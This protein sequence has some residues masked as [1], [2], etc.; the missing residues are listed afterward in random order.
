MSDRVQTGDCG[1]YRF[2]A[3]FVSAETGL[4]PCA[5]APDVELELTKRLSASITDRRA[6]SFMIADSRLLAPDSE[7][8][9]LFPSQLIGRIAASSSL[10][11]S[12]G[13][14]AG[15][16]GSQS[17]GPNP[18]RIRAKAAWS[19]LRDVLHRALKALR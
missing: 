4:S 2:R 8:R 11:P 16:P 1:I 13:V 9:L 10:C 17:S 15:R 5:Q 19:Q 14:H 3:L 7:E 18:L 6:S 12:T